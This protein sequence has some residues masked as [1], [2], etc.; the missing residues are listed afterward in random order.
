MKYLFKGMQSQERFELLLSLTRIQSENVISALFDYLVKG[1]DKKAAAMIN[2]V[3]LPN[4][5]VALNK[6]EEKALII[7]L[8]KEIDLR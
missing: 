6:L 2:G 7:E 5:S 3:E 1:M 4:L 8:I